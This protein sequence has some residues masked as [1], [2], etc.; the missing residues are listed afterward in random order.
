MLIQELMVPNLTTIKF[1]IAD[2][3][4]GS[5]SNTLT[6][7]WIYSSSSGN[8]GFTDWIS[9]LPTFT[10]RESYVAKITLPDQTIMY[11]DPFLLFSGEKKIISIVMINNIYY[12]S[13]W[14]GEK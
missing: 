7:S 12:T 10:E 8:D 4:N 11:F 6:F 2:D 1:K 13:I 5:V 9:A 14:M 3:K